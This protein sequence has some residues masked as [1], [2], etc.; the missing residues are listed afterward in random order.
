[1]LEVSLIF[2]FKLPIYIIRILLKIIGFLF[3]ILFGWIFGWVGEL[4]ENMSGEMFEDYVKEILKKNGYKKVRLTKS[5]GDYGTDI[6]AQY[7]GINYAFQCKLYTKPVGVAA[8]QQAYAGCEY[9]GCD[10]AVVVTNNTFTRQAINLSMSNGVI[11][12]DGDKLKQLRKRANRHS[13]LHCYK[14]EEDIIT[15]PYDPIIDLLLSEGYA[16]I[17]LLEDKFSFSKEK[18]YYLLE[19]LEFYELVSGE[20]ELGIRDI[21]FEDKEEA[22]ELLN[23]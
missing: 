19:D 10:E 2:I 6:I 20:D 11:L 3:Y 22:Y 8:I 18:A 17:S 9:Y 23:H 14:K 12:W 16:S 15:H 5:S 4:D 7:K 1:M 21:L 13:L